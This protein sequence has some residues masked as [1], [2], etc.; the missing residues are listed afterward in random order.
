LNYN[1]LVEEIAIKIYYSDGGCS[2]EDYEASFG[3]TKDHWKQFYDFQKEEDCLAEHERDDFRYQAKE[4]V[5]YLLRN[6]LLDV[7][8]TEVFSESTH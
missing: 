1:K 7:C 4:V 8:K 6:N 5:D 2:P 3:K